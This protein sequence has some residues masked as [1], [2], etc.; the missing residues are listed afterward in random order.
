M[1]EMRRHTDL[2]TVAKV[3]TEVRKGVLSLSHITIYTLKKNK[4]YTLDIFP[5]SWFRNTFW[6]RLRASKQ[7]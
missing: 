2:M 1:Y 4:M 3:V 5:S 6:D 7:F